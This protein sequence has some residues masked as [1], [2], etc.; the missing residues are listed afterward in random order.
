MDTKT[1][2]NVLIAITNALEAAKDE[3]ATAVVVI[4]RYL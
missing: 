2:V 1:A 4:L 3:L